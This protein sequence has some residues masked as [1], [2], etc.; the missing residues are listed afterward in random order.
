VSVALYNV[1]FAYCTDKCKTFIREH[2]GHGKAALIE[3][4]QQMAQI[5]PEYLDRV[6]DAFLQIKQSA[7]EAAS[8]YFQCFCAVITDCQVAGI[9]KSEWNK[10]K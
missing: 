2:Y 4:Q 8:S 3:L 10:V 9:Q 5:T 7:T 6:D 1:I